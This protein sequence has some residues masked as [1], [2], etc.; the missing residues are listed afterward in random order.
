MFTSLAFSST[1][2]EGT[3]IVLVILVYREHHIEPH[4]YVDREPDSSVTYS[5]THRPIRYRS[6]TNCSQYTQEYTELYLDGLSSV[7]DVSS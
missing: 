3:D 1:T 5:K 4:I 6:W 2:K 7:R